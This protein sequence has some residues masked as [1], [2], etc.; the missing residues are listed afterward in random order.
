MKR[1][2][3]P[4]LLALAAVSPALGQARGASPAAVRRAIE[5]NNKKFVEAFNRG[6]AAAIAAMYA[7]DARALPPNGDM[8][9]GR[10][11]IQALWRSAI[12]AGMKLVSLETVAVES[13]GD[14][15]FE[16]GKYT[17][18]LPNGQTDVGKYVVVWEKEGGVWRLA[19]DIWNSNKPAPVP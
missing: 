18:T 6:D 14:L 2:L 5:A 8:A 17:M 4:A 10:Q 16:V 19:A 1:I 15:A 12:V 9:E 3:L 7:R 13:R 11:E